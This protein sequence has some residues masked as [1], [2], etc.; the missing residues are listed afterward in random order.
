MEAM[1]RTKAG[2]NLDGLDAGLLRMLQS[3]VLCDAVCLTISDFQYIPTVT[4]ALDG[5]HGTGSAHGSGH[6]VDIRMK[7]L[8]GFGKSRSFRETAQA[9]ARTLAIDTQTECGFRPC[10]LVEWTKGSEHFHVQRG[11]QG[12]RNPSEWVEPL[13][14]EKGEPSWQ[15][16]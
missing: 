12:L 2:V 16:R 5:R 6:A 9:I 7:D 11:I 14:L 15:G 13:F 10:V 3:G 8:P 4:S 1:F